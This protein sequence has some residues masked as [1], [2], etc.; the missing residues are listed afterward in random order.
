MSS[1]AASLYS[2]KIYITK[3]S[4]NEYEMLTNNYT[5]SMYPSSTVGLKPLISQRAVTCRLHPHLPYKTIVIVSYR[6]LF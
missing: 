2:A 6:S 3:I 4:Y 1:I 5:L